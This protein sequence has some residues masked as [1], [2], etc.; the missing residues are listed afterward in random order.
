[1]VEGAAGRPPL[2]PQHRGGAQAGA[3]HQDLP[4]A[5]NIQDTI[6]GGAPG[7]TFN[8]MKLITVKKG[9]YIMNIIHYTPFI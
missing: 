3:D 8:K 4:G 9:K 1:M 2:S 6:L 7:L 5:G